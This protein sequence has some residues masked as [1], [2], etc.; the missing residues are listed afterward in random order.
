MVGGDKFDRNGEVTKVKC[1][2]S[3]WAFPSIE[4]GIV[5]VLGAARRWALEPGSDDILGPKVWNRH[6]E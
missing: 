3:R 4:L 6:L 2:T 5:F 1:K